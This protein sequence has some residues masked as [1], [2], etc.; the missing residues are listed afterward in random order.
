MKEWHNV[1]WSCFVIWFSMKI[2][3]IV[4]GKLVGASKH[5]ENPLDG[6]APGHPIR[7]R[8]HPSASE[9]DPLLASVF[10]L[11]GPET[12]R[13]SVLDAALCHGSASRRI[14]VLARVS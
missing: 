14:R 10:S 4:F 13:C 1:R 8:G 6:K 12:A 5:R 2:E 7:W 9:H 3:L 11:L